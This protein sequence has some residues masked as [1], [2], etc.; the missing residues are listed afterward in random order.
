MG[1]F[2]ERETDAFIPTA[3]HTEMDEIRGAE[4][5]ARKAYSDTTTEL[6]R[7]RNEEVRHFRMSCRT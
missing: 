4:K 7:L 5:A 6:Q 2:P 3:G 1:E